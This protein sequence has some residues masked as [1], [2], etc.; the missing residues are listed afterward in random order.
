LPYEHQDDLYKYIC[1][2]IKNKK[3]KPLQVN[4]IDDH[5][6]IMSDLHPSLSLSDYVKSI[7]ISSS[8]GM[9]ESGNFPEFEHWQG[10]YGAFTYSIREKDMILNYIKNQKQHHGKENFRTEFERL[11]VENGV[12][13]DEK[14]LL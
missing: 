6:H 9:K 7:K 2:V 13:F 12:K 4:G 1:G 8:I 11:L 14:Y 3:C 10:G 5:I